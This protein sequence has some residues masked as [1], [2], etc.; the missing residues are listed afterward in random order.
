VTH[1]ADHFAPVATTLAARV[2]GPWPT[3]RKFLFLLLASLAAW[4]L[5]LSALYAVIRYL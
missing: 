5:V 4:L 3:R 2:S 1:S